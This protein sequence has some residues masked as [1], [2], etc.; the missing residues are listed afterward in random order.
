MNEVWASRR[1]LFHW[2]CYV[3]CSISQGKWT[4]FVF[5]DKINRYQ[6]ISHSAQWFSPWDVYRYKPISHSAQW[7]SPWDVYR[8]KPI[9]HSAQWFS[10][11]DVSRYQ[12]ISQSVW[13]FYAYVKYSPCPT[14]EDG[15]LFSTSLVQRMRYLPK[16]SHLLHWAGAVFPHTAIKWMSFV[17]SDRHC[18]D[19]VEEEVLIKKTRLVPWP[20]PPS[21]SSWR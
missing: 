13:C 7:F 20:S 19:E 3:V 16:S 11:W 10:L 12:S 8:Y 18:T 5:S 6:P 21:S 1:T 4:A 17:N 2:T 9:S 15:W 14:K